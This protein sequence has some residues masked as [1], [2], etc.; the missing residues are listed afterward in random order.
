MTDP[1]PSKIVNFF[2]P[3]NWRV[4]LAI[5][6]GVFAALFFPY[7]SA[8]KVEMPKAPQAVYVGS[9]TNVDGRAGWYFSVTNPNETERLVDSLVE[10]LYDGWRWEIDD[11]FQPLYQQVDLFLCIINGE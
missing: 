8:K 9:G 11:P 10:G 6:V 2:R 1:Q 7:G 3:S 5:A 4:G